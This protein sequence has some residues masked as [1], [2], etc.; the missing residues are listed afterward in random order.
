MRRFLP[1]LLLFLLLAALCRAQPEPLA[2]FGSLNFAVDE[3]GTTA[4]FSQ[5]STTLTLTPPFSNGTTIGG[6]FTGAPY[7]WSSEASFGLLMSVPSSSPN[8]L[9][10]FY[11]LDELSQIINTY[12]GNVSGLSATPSVINLEL[13]LNP[14]FP[15]TGDLS[16]VGGVQFTWEGSG[17]STVVINGLVPEPSTWALLSLGGAFCVA[18]GLRRRGNVKGA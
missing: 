16:S 11:L 14:V 6:S 9:I 13:D 2:T 7:D 15:G 10:T 5:G 3:L 4:T 12:S 1:S 8:S 18:A 17:N